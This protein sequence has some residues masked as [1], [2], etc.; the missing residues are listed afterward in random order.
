MIRQE[1]FPLHLVNFSSALLTSIV[2]IVHLQYQTVGRRAITLLSVFFAPTRYR[3]VKI[4]CSCSD[5]VLQ[6]MKNYKAHYNLS[7]FRPLL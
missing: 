7:W 5:V 6:I 1:H 3:V 4:V 2:I